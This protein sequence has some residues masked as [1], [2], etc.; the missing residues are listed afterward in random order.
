MLIILMIYKNSFHKPKFYVSC[1]LCK[2]ETACITFQ[3]QFSDSNFK[4]FCQVY[5]AEQFAA[6]RQMVLPTGEEGYVRS[7]TRCIQWAARGGK[8]GSTFCKTRGL[9][10]ILPCHSG[11]NIAF[12]YSC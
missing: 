2:L 8:S 4:F 10:K 12:K 1:I 7:L 6:L 9:W 3:V 5:F 11:K